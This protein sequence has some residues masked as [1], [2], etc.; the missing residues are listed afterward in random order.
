MA[1]RFSV[2][3]AV[4]AILYLNDV[5]ETIGL[6]EYALGTHTTISIRNLDKNAVIKFGEYRFCSDGIAILQKEGALERSKAFVGTRGTLLLADVRGLHS[7]T[8]LRNCF[9]YA[10][11]HYFV[12][13]R[14]ARGFAEAW[15]RIGNIEA[16]S[17]PFSDSIR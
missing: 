1:S 10:L 2:Y 14:V 4:K 17:E 7:G 3:P 5:L 16:L 8:P 12:N 9:R 6:F 13:K 15:P 11:T